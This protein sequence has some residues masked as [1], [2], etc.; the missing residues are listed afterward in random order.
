MQIL[1][2]TH[3]LPYPPDKGER[4]RA[5]HE[6]KYLAAGHDI[7]LFCFADSN[8]D[9]KHQTACQNFCRTVYVEVLRKPARLLRAARAGVCSQSMSCAFF[10]SPKFAERVRQALRQR[11][12]DL[13]FVYCSSMGQFI[14]L[15]TST[16]IVV[17]FVDADSAKWAQY[18]QS[19][20]APKSWLYAREARA[21]A[22]AELELRNRAALSLVTTAHD[23][24]ELCGANAG[25]SPVDVMPN[26]VEIPELVTGECDAAIRGL[27][28]FALFVGTMDYKPN[29][30]AAE[31]FARNIFPKLRL[32][33]PQLK[34]VIVGR[35]PD[36]KVRR[37]AA[38]PGVTVTGSVPDVYKYFRNAD[39]S[40]APFR[41]SQ[42]FH[43]KI[44][45]SL[46]VGTAVVTSGRAAAGIGLSEK[47]GLFAAD[48]SEQ[49]VEIVDFVLSHSSLR[50]Q[51]R[52]SSTTTRKLLSWEPH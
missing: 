47:E 13:I 26:G 38:L 32:R 29:S 15:D 7:D 21:V 8:E 12:Y 35:N 25:R 36:G 52:A 45:E 10:H 39:I 19:C 16:P 30:D 22:A 3:R 49:F 18:A 37:L 43:N 28:P 31:H 9:A 14:P 34:F 17:D 2:L 4:I 51:L 40:V 33:R 11:P 23:A 5:F 20:G 27:Q 24:T 42:G 1:F 46:A 48:T 41:L 6:L 50:Q 44:A